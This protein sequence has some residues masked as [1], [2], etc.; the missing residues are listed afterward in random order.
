MNSLLPSSDI[1]NNLSNPFIVCIGLGFSSLQH[2]PPLQHPTP[3]KFPTMNLANLF[4]QVDKIYPFFNCGSSIWSRWPKSRCYNFA[5]LLQSSTINII[6]WQ[7]SQQKLAPLPTAPPPLKTHYGTLNCNHF[8][9][10]QKSLKVNIIYLQ[11]DNPKNLSLNGGWHLFLFG[12]W[13]F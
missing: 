7:Y 10:Q 9:T 1:V 13:G 4:L 5:P 11:R 6:L 3:Y 2:P 8:F 12:V